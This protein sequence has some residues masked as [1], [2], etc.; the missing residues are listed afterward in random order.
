MEEKEYRI[1]DF[2]APDYADPVQLNNP[3][4]SL[5]LSSLNGSSYVLLVLKSNSHQKVTES[6][7]LNLKTRN[8]S[9]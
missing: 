2:K 8:R 9:V 7:Q 6:T 4:V 5:S 3:I 1:I